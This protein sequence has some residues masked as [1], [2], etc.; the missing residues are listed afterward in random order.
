MV[1]SPRST[2]VVPAGMSI[3]RS[4]TGPVN[5]EPSVLRATGTTMVCRVRPLRKIA[6]PSAEKID[7]A[8]VGADRSAAAA[9]RHGVI[10]HAVRL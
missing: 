4:N 6:L 10:K 7:A 8:I 1:S 9:V 3:N 2:V 5:G